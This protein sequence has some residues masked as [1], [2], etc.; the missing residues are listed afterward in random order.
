MRTD[1]VFL[2]SSSAWPAAAPRDDDEGL[3]E[4]NDDEGL[5]WDEGSWTGIQGR[6]LT[7]GVL[8]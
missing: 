1:A 3:E 4:G 8:D 2:A 7:S 6:G 5:D